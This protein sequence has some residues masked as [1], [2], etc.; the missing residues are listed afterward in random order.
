MEG[1]GAE[2]AFPMLRHGTHMAHRKLEE[3][4]KA[5]QLKLA[6]W[7]QTA[8]RASGSWPL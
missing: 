5:N 4:Q 3:Q 2:D 8:V 6:A 1:L 7:M